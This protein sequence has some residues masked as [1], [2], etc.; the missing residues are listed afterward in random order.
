MTFEAVMLIRGFFLIPRARAMALTHPAQVLKLDADHVQRLAASLAMRCTNVRS[1]VRCWAPPQGTGTVAKWSTGSHWPYVGCIGFISISNQQQ[2]E[3][4]PSNRLAQTS[5]L[6]WS[7][8]T[9]PFRG[10]MRRKGLL[11]F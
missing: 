5:Q 7:P 4:E 8:S 6:V 3:I 11:T 9:S 2:P 1:S 10:T